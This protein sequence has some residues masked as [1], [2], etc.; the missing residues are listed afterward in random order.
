MA[1]L[2][3]GETSGLKVV[4]LAQAGATAEGAL[5]QARGITVENAVVLVEIG[6]NDL[7][8]NTDSGAFEHHLD[9]LLA[10]VRKRGARAVMFELPLPPFCNAFGRAQRDLA[11]KHGV[12]LIPKR[13]MTE[14]LGA[15]GG[16]LDGL[17]LSDEGHAVLAKRLRTILVPN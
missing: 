10:E 17:H 11:A 12:A 9:S 4:N 8:G 7:L 5:S 2:V 15:K 6:G 1:D 13:C 16:T 14:A 3:L